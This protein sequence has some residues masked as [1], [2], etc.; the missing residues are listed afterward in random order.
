MTTASLA[1]S[2]GLAAGACHAPVPLL[3]AAITH[4]EGSKVKAIG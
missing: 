3:E 4:D 1:E 2:E